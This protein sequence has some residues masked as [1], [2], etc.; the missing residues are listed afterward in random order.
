LEAVLREIETFGF[1][2]DPGDY[3][4]TIFGQ[5]AAESKWGWRFE[6]HHISLNMAFKDGRLAGPTPCFFGANPAVV[7][8]GP[9]TGH[10]MLK[11]EIGAARA[12]LE[13]INDAQRD[14][15]L[16]RDRAF[17]DIVAGP[18]REESLATQEGLAGAE[19]TATQRDL[20][21]KLIDRFVGVLPA[22]ERADEI[23]RLQAHGLEGVHFAWAGSTE[24]GAGHYFRVHGPQILI[25]YDNS[26]NN[27]NHVHSIWLDPENPFGKDIL[28]AHYRTGHRHA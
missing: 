18:R 2:R 8:S 9:L 24:P 5:P 4:F 27:A 10:E 3:Y 11:D 6:G 15:V 16:I 19:M 20:L 23:A 13:T 1:S 7:P 14:Q 28:G 25:E 22:Q 21:G 17:G 12:L 26:R